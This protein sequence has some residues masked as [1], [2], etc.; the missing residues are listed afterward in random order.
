MAA[1]EDEEKKQPLTPTPEDE[2][3][4]DY[5]MDMDD[6]PPIPAPPDGGN[7]NILL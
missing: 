7:E 6:E 5:N 3:L 4:L 2:E 1:R